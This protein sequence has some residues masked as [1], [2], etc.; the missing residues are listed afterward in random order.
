MWSR[1]S[2]LT[3]LPT[4]SSSVNFAKNKDVGAKTE[5]KFF[6][7]PKAEMFAKTEA[8]TKR[9]QKMQKVQKM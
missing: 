5:C 7:R 2:K 4:L 8:N 3:A 9:K 1:S 6:V